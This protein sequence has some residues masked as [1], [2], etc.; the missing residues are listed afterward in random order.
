MTPT[1]EDVVTRIMVAAPGMSV[2]AGQGLGGVWIELTRKWL[3][4]ARLIE[5]RRLYEAFPPGYTFLIRFNVMGG[6][7]NQPF[8]T[9]KDPF[10]ITYNGKKVVYLHRE[11]HVSGPETLLHTLVNLSQLTPTHQPTA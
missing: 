10:P 5:A 7:A 4:E 8:I 6:S 3:D 11:M 1:E 2:R 9:G